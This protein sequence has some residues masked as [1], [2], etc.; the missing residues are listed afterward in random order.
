MKIGFLGTGKISSSMVDG[1]MASTFDVPSII[2]SP[3]SVQIAERLARDYDKVT[4]AESNQALLDASDC[5]FLCLPNQIAE[6]VLRSLRFRPEQLV[7]SVLAMAEASE[8][9]K[10]IN[11]KVYR[12]VPLPFVA[13]C[14]NLTPIYPEHPFLRTLF[15]ALGGALVLDEE[16]QFNL[17]MTAG[18]LMGV[19]FN[20]M[21]TAHQWLVK[22]GL[23]KQKSVDFLTMMFGNL[24]DEMR[25]IAVNNGQTSINFTLLER[26]FSTKGGTNELVSSC[27]SRQGGRAALTT[28]LEAALQT[29]NALNS[30]NT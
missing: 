28:A 20:F 12:A 13:E 6:E 4:I 10:W 17:F 26:E 7:V 24:S 29:M 8:V 27:F 16:D 5:V 25:K 22:Q 15:D 18:S 14:K 2:V 30:K 3:R 21:E 23:E 11:H 9:E 19:Y 1:L